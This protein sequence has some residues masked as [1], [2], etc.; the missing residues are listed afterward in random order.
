MSSKAQREAGMTADYG[1]TPGQL[2]AMKEGSVESVVSSP[3]YASLGAD[4][5]GH[6]IVGA[7]GS[8]GRG[9]KADQATYGESAGQLGAMREGSVESVVSSPPYA[10]CPIQ[11][12]GD[13]I[14][15]GRERLRETG[16]WSGDLTDGQCK[17]YG[18]A[19]GQ[20]ARMPE[21]AAVMSSPP[22]EDQNACNDPKYREG[23]RSSGEPLHGEYGTSDGQLGV[24]SGETFWSA[25]HQIVSECY[26]AI[27]PGSHAIWVTKAFVRKGKRVDFPGQW[28]D[29]CESVGF[30]TVHEHEAWFCHWDYKQEKLVWRKSFFR[31]LAESKGSP[32]IDWETILCMEK[33]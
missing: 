22:F 28:R 26:R 5:K 15:R 16:E 10:G 18:D 1:T 17:S 12:G 8:I 14:K 25:A 32:V 19:P 27:R 11:A 9:C 13:N 33:A 21:G 4:T 31:R 6:G 2:G 29:L 7:K 30:R 24:D 20:L 3:P 23:R